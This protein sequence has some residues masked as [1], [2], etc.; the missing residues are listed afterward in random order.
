MPGRHT[1]DRR[2]KTSNPAQAPPVII[3]LHN[4]LTEA[5]SLATRLDTHPQHAHH[6]ALFLGHD[7]NVHARTFVWLDKPSVATGRR[8]AGPA[9][10]SPASGGVLA[11]AV[12]VTLGWA[13]LYY[14]FGSLLHAW[15]SI[16]GWSQ[17][18]LAIGITGAM[19]ISALLAPAVG[20]QID[21]GRGPAVMSLGMVIGAMAVA[22][23]ALVGSMPA[24]VIAWLVIGVGQATSLYEACFAL[25]TRCRPQQATG[26]IATITLAAGF[27]STLAFPLAA[28]LTEAVGWRGAALC[29]AGLLGLVAA[30]LLWWGAHQLERSRRSPAHPA[31]EPAKRDDTVDQPTNTAQQRRIPINYA[32]FWSLALAFPLIALV[33]GIMLTHIIPLLLDR[34]FNHGV[35][36]GAAALF[37]PTQVA[38]RLL[39]LPA[40]RRFGALSLTVLA[41]TIVAVSPLV[42]LLGGAQPPVAFVF[43]AC[44][45]AGYGVTSILKPVLTVAVLGER[46]VGTVM[47]VLAMPFMAALAVSPLVGSLLAGWGGYALALAVAF[48]LAI[49]G[50]MVLSCLP[51]LR[52]P[53]R[54]EQQAPAMPVTAARVDSDNE[55]IVES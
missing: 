5:L 42:L 52:W 20:R 43:S 4:S 46:D 48:G 21:R 35:A 14:L 9:R 13:G 31:S 2:T 36:V 29:F 8:S 11:L 32:A 27:A 7:R 25:V 10:M 40:L 54:L 41:F 47:G 15:T 55:A 26:S 23:L 1:R 16:E 51:W 38:C 24:F 50:V 53:G 18:H 12:G 44:F 3:N 28:T 22:A 34:G 6:A 45:A 30:P 49:T 33:E 17:A 19:L 39:L 37:G